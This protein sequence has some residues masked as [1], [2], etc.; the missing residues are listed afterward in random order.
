MR[1]RTLHKWIGIV[2]GLALLMWAITGIIM[3]LPAN[4]VRDSRV[5][6]LDLTRATISP[7]QALAGLA[8]RDSTPPVRSLVLIQILDQL[9]YQVETTRRTL[10][11]SAET[12]DRFEVTPGMAEAI[13]RASFRGTPGTI[14]VERLDKYDARYSSGD[15]PAY[16]V[17]LGDQAATISYVSA[18]NGSVVSAD[19]RRRMRSVVGK[20]HDFS[21]LRVLTSSDWVRRGLAIGACVLSIISILTGYWLALPRR[22]PARRV[23]ST[24]PM[25]SARSSEK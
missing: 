24:E 16:R 1:F 7:A 9:V 12:G 23:R 13:A 2:V 17:S 4:R 11:V 3:M 8:Q 10:L 6:A 14:G 18:R 15:L 19:S 25:L 22:S 21:A 20:L 5:A